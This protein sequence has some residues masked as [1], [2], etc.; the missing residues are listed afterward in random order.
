MNVIAHAVE[1]KIG[2]RPHAAKNNGIPVAFALRGVHARC[3]VN[4][5]TNGIIP[6]LRNLIGCDNGEALRDVNNWRWGFECIDLIGVEGSAF[7]NN[8]SSSGTSWA[9]A[10]GV[11][12]SR[13]AVALDKDFKD[14]FYFYWIEF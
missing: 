14:M 12:A 11:S 7:D 8:T 6:A 3:V 10:D 9:K 5:L 2:G 4:D 13:I 1:I